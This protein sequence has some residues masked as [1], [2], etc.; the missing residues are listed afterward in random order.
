[1]A[2]SIFPFLVGCER[3]GTT[4]VRA[5]LDGHPQLAVPGESHFIVPM[6]RRRYRY[7]RRGAFDQM[8][9]VDDLVRQP[10]LRTWH[11]PEALL[12]ET[13]EAAAPASF[14]DA[15]RLLYAIY[16]RFHGK[17][18][19]ADKTP[20]YVDRMVFLS[21][22]FPE[23]RFVHVIRDGRAV[24]LSLRTIGWVRD[25]EEGALRWRQQVERG[26]RAGRALG[27]ARY[28]ELRYENLVEDPQRRLE[29]VCAFIGL[30]FDDAMLRYPDRADA[31]LSTV[32]A[33]QKLHRHLREPPRK[34]R[35]WRQEM[36]TEE[37]AAFEALAGG[38]L[39]NVGYARSG[40]R[41]TNA[42][43]RA[44]R[45][46]ARWKFAGLQRR[47]RGLLRR[48]RPQRAGV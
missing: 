26:R 34:V 32:L 14:A 12:R 33:P 42:P 3:S 28:R 6:A 13:Y 20:Q 48:V 25:I 43:L 30:S 8:A 44:L 46:G 39:A 23:A 17:R 31:I 27:P 38:T 4:L 19:Y 21:R 37:V 7:R 24:A 41:I 22:L 47:S 11:I 16:A 35:D 1:M 18:Y 2:E 40:H 9:F 15:I 10:R 36:T 29:G 45:V 5:M